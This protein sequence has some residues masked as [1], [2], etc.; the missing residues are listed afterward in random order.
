MQEGFAQTLMDTIGKG[1]GRLVDADMNVAS[2]RLTALQTQE[3]LAV[4]GLQIAN[5]HAEN[6]MELF[7]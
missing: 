5:G 4:Q 3:Q 2:T 7:R 6:V 1:I